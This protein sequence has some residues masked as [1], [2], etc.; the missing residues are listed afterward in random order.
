LYAGADLFVFPS[1]LETFGHPLVEA[2]ASGV[3]IAASNAAAIPEICSD[4]AIYFDPYDVE[5]MASTI[6]R[7]L[8]NDAMRDRLIRNGGERVKKF[9]WAESAEQMLNL[10]VSAALHKFDPVAARDIP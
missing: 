6:H 5:N 8:E 4:A 1:L 2:M 7:V 10:F 9:S 3:P